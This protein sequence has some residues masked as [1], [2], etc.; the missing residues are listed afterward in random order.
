VKVLILHQ[1]FNTPQKGGALRSYYLAKA[2]ADHGH[3]PV[4]ITAHSEKNYRR[5]DIEGIEVHYMPIAYNN[6]FGFYKRS[7][8]FIRF[9]LGAVKLAGRFRDASVCYAIS[10]PLTIGIAAIWIEKRYKIPF[11]FEVGDLWPDAPVQ[12]GYIQNPV[13]KQ[14]LYQL[15]KTLYRKAKAVVALSPMIRSAIERKV[16]GTHVHLIPNMADTDFY[17]PQPKDPVLES[18]YNVQDKF[19]ISYIGAVGYANGLDYYLEC[20]RASQRANLPIRFLLCGDGA[21]LD[22]LK[23]L[24][25]QIQLTNFS[26]IPFQDREGVR[27]VMNVTDAS[28]TCYRPVPILE[29]GSPNKYF[30]GL[31]AGK[32]IIINFGGWIRDEIESRS[33]G[34]YLDPKNPAQLIEKIQP[35]LLDKDLQQQYRAC[36]R[37]LALEKYSRLKL[38]ESFARIFSGY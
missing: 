1:H 36:S 24:V 2:L 29:T 4:V 27:E 22:R 32:I 23:S 9:V 6:R 15:E 30:D 33:C 20:A 34:I 11:I 31:A 38:G 37:E 16:P 25:T 8:S 35:L 13:F 26:F 3:T 18:K 5:E 7:V 10:V 19:V 12:L 14:S 17:K 21:M 28:F